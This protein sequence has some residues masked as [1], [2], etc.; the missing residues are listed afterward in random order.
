MQLMPAT[1]QELGRQ[2]HGMFSVNR[3]TEPVTNIEIGTLHL[4]QLFALFG[5]ETRL[6]IASYNAGTGERREMAPRRAAQTDGRVSRV[7][8]VRRDAQLRQA[9]DAPSLVVRAHGTVAER[10]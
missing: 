5:G 8:A 6:V 4:K 10:K 7:D 3:L 1:G 2:L 9:R